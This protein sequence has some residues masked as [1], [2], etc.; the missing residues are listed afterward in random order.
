MAFDCFPTP[1]FRARL[2]R[3]RRICSLA[4]R[5]PENPAALLARDGGPFYNFNKCEGCSYQC[6]LFLLP[7]P[8]YRPPGRGGKPLTHIT[9]LLVKLSR[10]DQRLGGVA[11]AHLRTP[12]EWGTGRVWELQRQVLCRAR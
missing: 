10:G 3:A 2:R 1:G 11:A 5:R 4:W 9:Q 8:L 12:V 6:A 7:R